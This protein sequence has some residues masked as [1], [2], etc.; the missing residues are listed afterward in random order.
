MGGFKMDTK[1]IH[2]H[3]LLDSRKNIE[4]NLYPLKTFAAW[5]LFANKHHISPGIAIIE[6]KGKII[7]EHYGMSAEDVV[8]RISRHL[9][10]SIMI[11]EEG[12]KTLK[13]FL[14][15]CIN[16]SLDKIMGDMRRKETFQV[17]EPTRAY[18]EREIDSRF[19]CNDTSPEQL[20][21]RIEIF[22]DIETRKPSLR[23]PTTPTVVLRKKKTEPVERTFLDLY[24]DD[25]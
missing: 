21:G 5:A 4:A 18:R 20:D 16:Y 15:S 24:D 14:L 17:P 23:K 1:Y 10:I 3:Q 19:M 7:I 25:F 13:S 2:T 9:I 11:Y 22:D 6:S 12:P 8:E